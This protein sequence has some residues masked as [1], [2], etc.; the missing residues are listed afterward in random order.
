[1]TNIVST[2]SLYVSSPSTRK[3][4]A[5]LRL[6]FRTW[7]CSKLR[8]LL[9]EFH[10]TNASHISTTLSLHAVRLAGNQSLP[11]HL[12]CTYASLLVHVAQLMYMYM[13]I[14]PV[15]R[16]QS[17]YWPTLYLQKHLIQTCR[18][19]TAFYT[20]TCTLYRKLC[21]NNRPLKSCFPFSKC[22]MYY[23]YLSVIEK[24]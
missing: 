15:L 4:T 9:S 13:H 12:S 22:Y 16:R 19:S 5:N 3:L 18:N 14:V 1:M 2:V 17:L 8:T 7:E 24:I 21:V 6:Y 23:M 20:C 10:L 11:V